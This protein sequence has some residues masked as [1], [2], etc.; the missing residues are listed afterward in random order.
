M[1]VWSRGQLLCGKDTNNFHFFFHE[2]FLLP[3]NDKN[4]NKDLKVRHLI[5]RKRRSFHTLRRFTEWLASA[6]ILG[7]MFHMSLHLHLLITWLLIEV[8]AALCPVLMPHIPAPTGVVTMSL[9]LSLA[10]S[11][12]HQDSSENSPQSGASPSQHS[13]ITSAHSLTEHSW[14][15][16]EKLR[17]RSNVQI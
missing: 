7:I 8:S 3:M 15:T 5:I 16:R 17:P 4:V 1:R 13:F 2:I 9:C 6:C 14:N 10:A 11:C 12:R